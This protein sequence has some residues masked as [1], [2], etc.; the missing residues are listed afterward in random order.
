MRNDDVERAV[1]EERE[2]CAALADE[3]AEGFRIVLGP[4]WAERVKVS[5]REIAGR[6]RDRGRP[7]TVT[8]TPEELAELVATEREGCAMQAE[9]AVTPADAAAMIRARGRI[10]KVSVHPGARDLVDAFDKRVPIADPRRAVYPDFDPARHVRPSTLEERVAA[11]FRDR[12]AHDRDWTVE[13]ALV[14]ELVRDE[15]LRAGGTVPPRAE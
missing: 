2:A 3:F 4:E 15:I 12:F 14:V 5:A 6:I 11:F 9:V 1:A 10:Q 13:R 7:R 8:R